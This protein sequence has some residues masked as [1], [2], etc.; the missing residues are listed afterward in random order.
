MPIKPFWG[1][2]LAALLAAIGIAAVFA[3]RAAPAAESP[4]SPISF[5]SSDTTSEYDFL[6]AQQSLAR[7]VLRT[8]S[9]TQL[10]IAQARAILTL[11]PIQHLYDL[12][13]RGHPPWQARAIRLIRS[14]RS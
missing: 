12:Q 11:D 7:S 4:D 6:K 3:D 1:V 2:L 13:A 9:S 5:Y 14:K 10:E 8:P